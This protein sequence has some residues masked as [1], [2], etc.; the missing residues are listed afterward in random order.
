M[1]QGNGYSDARLEGERNVSLEQRI[2]EE[3]AKYV[4]LQQLQMQLMAATAGV[5]GLRMDASSA[6]QQASALGV[7]PLQLNG[8][9]AMPAQGTLAEA[10]GFG[11]V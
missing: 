3:E 7:Q 9:K 8:P 2:A 1:P 11:A 5:G 10:G 6:Q 4:Q